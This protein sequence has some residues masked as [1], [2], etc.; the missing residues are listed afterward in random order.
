MKS[1]AVQNKKSKNEFLSPHV[2][3][4]IHKLLRNS[5]NQTVKWELMSRNPVQNASLPKEEHKT[6]EIWIM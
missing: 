4:E 1:K 2:I 6:R 3:R 5:F